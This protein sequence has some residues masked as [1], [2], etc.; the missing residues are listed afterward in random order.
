MTLTETPAC[1]RRGVPVSG[2]DTME[3]L[4]D[5]GLDAEQV[6]RLIESG[7]AATESTGEGWTP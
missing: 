5:L 1:V 2:A 3:V 4:A 7:V 6:H